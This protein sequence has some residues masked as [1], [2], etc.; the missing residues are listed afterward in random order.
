MMRKI[1]ITRE[2]LELLA[3]IVILVC[4][5]SVF[6]LKFGSKATLTYEGGKI[7]YTGYVLN[8][9]MNGQGKLTYPNGDVYEGHFVNGIFNGHG[10]FK[11]SVG[12]SYVGEFKKGQADGHGKLTAKDKKIYKGTF[13]QGIYQK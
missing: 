13:K 4:G 3:V 1:Q 12:W 2:K 5:L 6:T 11:S 10:R 7:N 9:R 8:H